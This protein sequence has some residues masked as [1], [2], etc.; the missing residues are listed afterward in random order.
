MA[1]LA[2]SPRRENGRPVVH[3]ARFQA[4]MK[5][6][7]PVRV[8]SERAPDHF[9]HAVGWFGHIGG[10]SAESAIWSQK[11]ATMQSSTMQWV[12]K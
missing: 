12:E 7:V 1:G 9:R 3:S 4:P 6:A 11:E 8:R 2:F 10:Q 5:G